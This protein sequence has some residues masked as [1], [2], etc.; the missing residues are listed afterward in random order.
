MYNSG[1]I[2]VN[3]QNTYGVNALLMAG[4]AANESA[5]GNS[6]IAQ[7]KNNLFGLNA[8]DSA[9]GASADTYTSPEHCIREL[10]M[11]GCP[12]DIFM[13]KTGGILEDFLEIKQVE[14]M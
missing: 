10:Q 14:L 6:S 8:V 3:M 13:Q 11:S 7:T 12:V 2:F 1:S 4:V 9:P 5:W